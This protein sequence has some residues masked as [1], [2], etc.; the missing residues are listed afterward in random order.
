M[1]WERWVAPAR[2]LFLIRPRSDADYFLRVCCA[3][4]DAYNAF[5]EHF[6]FKLNGVAN[7]KTHLVLRRIKQSTQ[8]PL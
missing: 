6:L 8:L 2:H 1:P 5:L 3:D 7:I 4:L